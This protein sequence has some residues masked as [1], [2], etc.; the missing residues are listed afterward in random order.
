MSIRD[1]ILAL[2][3]ERPSYGYRLRAEFEQRTGATWP[4]NVGQVYTTLGRLERDGLVES[5]GEDAE[6]H[7]YYRCTEGG[8][9]QA[10]DWFRTPVSRLDRP[11]D[12]LAIKIALAVRAPGVE[13]L[14][15]IQRQR[16]ETISSL[17]DLTALKR[18]GGE[19][20]VGWTLIVDAMVFQAE[21]EVSW[22]DHC[23][24][25]IRSGLPDPGSNEPDRGG[26]VSPRPAAVA[27]RGGKTDE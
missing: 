24:A 8:G 13:A 22:L 15:V 23:E 14:E 9:A 25:R 11:R 21:A 16:S 7:V 20:E 3:Q 12:E 10:L 18:Q 19:E 2:L 4:L 5:A 1:G 27:E 26:D 6:G 17:R